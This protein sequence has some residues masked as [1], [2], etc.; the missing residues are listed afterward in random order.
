MAN[1][2]RWDGHVTRR[3]L[4]FDDEGQRKNERL[5][6]AWR[7]QAEEESVTA[8]LRMEDAICRSM[9]LPHVEGN[10]SPAVVGVLLDWRHC[11]LTLLYTCGC[12][13][14]INYS[15]QWFSML[16]ITSTLLL[17]K[18]SCYSLITFINIVLMFTFLWKWRPS[19]TCYRKQNQLN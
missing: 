14:V 12:I 2:V 15:I 11:F 4:E 5:K 13:H 17:Y 19:N 16:L 3:A 6:M 9:S 10:R 18:V 1:S 8:G 7:K